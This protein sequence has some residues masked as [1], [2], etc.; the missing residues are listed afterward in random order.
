MSAVDI[1]CAVCGK[2]RKISGKFADRPRFCSREC[3]FRS[4]RFNPRN[5]KGQKQSEQAI[6]KIAN[7]KLG[8]KVTAETIQKL[9]VAQSKA[10][11]KR[12]GARNYRWNPDRDAVNGKRA[13]KK[14]CHGFIWNAVRRMPTYDADEVIPELGWSAQR[15]RERLEPLLQPGM[16]WDNHGVRGW[17]IDHIRPISSFPDGTPLSVINELTNLRPLWARDNLS[18]GAKWLQEQDPSSSLTG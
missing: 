17:H 6:A 10:A 15:L 12:S 9:R 13:L 1:A 2:P 14:A 11:W 3:F 7:A 18:K 4:P 5:R 16:T 8:K